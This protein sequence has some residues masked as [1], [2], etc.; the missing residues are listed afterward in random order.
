MPFEN[1]IQL[2]K[3]W[4]RITIKD[5]RI[6][7]KESDKVKIFQPFMTTKGQDKGT[8]LGLPIIKQIVAKYVGFIL[9]NS[10]FHKG[11][12]FM[13]NLPIC[14]NALD[15]KNASYHHSYFVN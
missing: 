9:F 1:N 4:I 2:K 8:G 5:N 15:W 7:I 11:T 12:S 6:G 10:Q 13:V 3:N 14:N